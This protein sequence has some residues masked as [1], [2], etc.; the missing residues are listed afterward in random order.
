ME[1]EDE[2]VL[3]HD[4]CKGGVEALLLLRGADRWSGARG[5]G[6]AAFAT[7][8]A[9][10]HRARYPR[11]RRLR[12]RRYYTTR[13]SR[14]DLKELSYKVRSAKGP[15]TA[16]SDFDQ[17]PRFCGRRQE[18]PAAAEAPWDGGALARV[19]YRGPGRRGECGRVSGPSPVG[20]ARPSMS[21]G[22]AGRW[23]LGL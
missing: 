7:A 11:T 15:V 12:F 23:S 16:M 21:Y 17:T 9:A 18:G 5:R 20:A 10:G 4:C 8:A 3:T 22:I 2:D 1:L 14:H 19:V 6:C 13:V